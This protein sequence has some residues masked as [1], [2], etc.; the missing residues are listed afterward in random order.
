MVLRIL[1]RRNGARKLSEERTLYACVDGRFWRKAA[2][3]RNGGRVMP[4][5]EVAPR[6]FSQF[7]AQENGL[8]FAETKLKNSVYSRYFTQISVCKKEY[9]V[10]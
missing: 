8:Q 9:R 7:A 4:S 1:L 5:T 2:G 3:H 6:L 10:V